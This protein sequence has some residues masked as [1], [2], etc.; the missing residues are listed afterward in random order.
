[1]PRA[2]VKEFRPEAGFGTLAL[3]DGSEMSFDVAASN[4]RDVRAGETCEATIAP[5]RT[6]RPKVTLVVF[7]LKA[8]RSTDLD[9]FVTYAHRNG[10]L[11][12]WT[13]ADAKRAVRELFDGGDAM[14]IDRAGAAA[15]LEAY[16]DHGATLRARRDRVLVLDW[17]NCQEEDVVAAFKEITDVPGVRVLK[18]LGGAVVLADA[19]GVGAEESVDLTGTLQ[20]LGDWFDELLDR[21]GRRERWW[22][23]AS[24]GDCEIFV[25]RDPAS[26]QQSASDLPLFPSAS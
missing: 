20:P 1:M 15:M 21:A 19:A 17:Q 12:D 25:L 7:P 5:G 13:L 2:I 24:D 6:G 11:T 23:V 16:Y 3:E 10:L 22:P 18:H 14:R 9:A 26:F 4:K 8:H